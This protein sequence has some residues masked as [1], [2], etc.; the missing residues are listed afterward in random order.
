MNSVVGKHQLA[1]C[2]FMCMHLSLRGSCFSGAIKS[3][4]KS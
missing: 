2:I 4:Y 3:K 1:I